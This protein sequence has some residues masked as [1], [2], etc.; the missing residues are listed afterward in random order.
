M[1]V[2]IQSGIHPRTLV[3]QIVSQISR[4]Q[5]IDL[6]RFID[7]D[8]VQDVDFTRELCDYF[9]REMELEQAH[10]KE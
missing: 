3:R 1:K 5:L 9:T 10:E 8:L 7:K 2:G 4:D 6:I